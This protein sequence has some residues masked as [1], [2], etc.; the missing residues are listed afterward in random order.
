M[1]NLQD[2]EGQLREVNKNLKDK[3]DFIFSLDNDTFRKELTENVGKLIEMEKFPKEKLSKYKRTVGVDGSNNRSGG[4]FPHFIEIF[5]GLAKSTDGNEVYK[6]KVYTPTLNDIYEDKNLSQK[7]LATI[8]IETA[9]EYI[10]KYDFDYLMMDGGFIRY[11][12]NCLDLFTELRETC[13]AK[14]IILFGVI[15]DLKTNVIARSLEIDESIYDREILFNRLKTGE[16]V[17]IRNEINKKFIK[18]GLGEGFSS[19]FMRTSK[20]PGAVGLD[21]LDTQEK[22]LEE[23]SKLIYTLTPMSSRGVPLW[24]DIV[25][26]DVKITDEILTTLLE[27][28][29]DRDVYERFFISE[30]DKRSL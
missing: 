6:N 23:I 3:Y 13:E 14:N 15:K 11:K 29:L 8:E 21:I 27:E 5:Q 9:L 2:L 25:D 19:A 18:D 4:A 16:A 28:Y 12:I 17:L 30:R 7:Y 22:Y 20:F 1:I 26:K 24:L 10:N